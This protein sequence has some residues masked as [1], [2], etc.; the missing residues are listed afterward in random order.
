MRKGSKND[1]NSLVGK[2]FGR[3]SVTSKIGSIQGRAKNR[4]WY[5]CICTCG[6]IITTSSALLT[7]GRKLS[8]GCLRRELGLEQ[9]PPEEAGYRDAYRVYAANAQRR[10]VN[11]AI[12]LDKFKEITSS[13]CHY[14]GAKGSLTSKPNNTVVFR[15]NG[16]DRKDNSIGY[17]PENCLPCC[18]ICNRAKRDISY[19]EFLAWISS[20][21][22]HP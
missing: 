8:C 9:L 22:N 17:Y 12:T 1:N 7:R 4:C 3:L 11:F 13:P 14:C 10:K 19:D 16:V 18:K 21:R 20:I 6:S 5:E 15:L 2:V